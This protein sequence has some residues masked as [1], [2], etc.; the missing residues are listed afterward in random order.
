[1]A[2]PEGFVW[3]AASAAYQSEGGAAEGGRTPSIWD[4]FSHTPGCTRFGHTGDTACDGYH[5]WA[6]DLDL[7]AQAGIPNYRFSISWT[8]IFPT[9][10]ET[11][12]AAGLAYYDAVVDGCRQRG[13]TPWITLYHWD[14]P[15]Y[16]QEQGGWENAAAAQA[17]GRLAGVLAAHFRGRVRQYI[18]LNEPACVVGLGYESGQHAPGLRLAKP[19]VFACVRHVLLAHGYAARAIRAADPDA[20]VGIVTTGRLCWP[21]GEAPADEA[22]AEAATFAPLGGGGW[23][24]VHHLYLDPVVRGCWPACADPE[25]AALTAAVPAAEMAQIRAVPDFIGLNIYSGQPVRAG[26]APGTWAEVPDVPGMPRTSLQWPITPAVMEYG[27]LWVQRRYGLPVY[28]TENGRSCCDAVFLDGAVHDADRIDFLHRYLLALQRGIARGSGVR[29]YFQWSL[30]DNFEWSEGYEP[31]FGLIY[32][33]Y[34]DG[35]RIPKDSLRW[36]G[37]VAAENGALL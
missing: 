1:M 15:Q 3:G 28:I 5:R 19:Q 33:D 26:A 7:L 27:P 2:F 30:T 37:R 13:I 35:R 22:A 32:I 12:C 36:Y 21:A 14:L 31:R 16:L 20:R 25:L 34:A 17:F 9:P 24:F 8:R 11:P 18:T 23:T 29:G 6:Q 10:D 4:V